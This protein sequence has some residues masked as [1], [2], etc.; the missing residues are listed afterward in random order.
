M[1]RKAVGAEGKREAAGI[2]KGN[3]VGAAAAPVRRNR[4]TTFRLGKQVLDRWRSFSL[5]ARN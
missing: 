3:G 1:T 4:A 2:E 5:L